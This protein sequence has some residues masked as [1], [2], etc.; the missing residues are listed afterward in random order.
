MLIPHLEEM[1]AR[2]LKSLGHTMEWQIENPRVWEKDRFVLWAQVG[3][4]RIRVLSYVAML[5]DILRLL[6]LLVQVS[7]V[8]DC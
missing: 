8:P 2:E 5:N 6:V 4:C 1:Y 7:W 3:V